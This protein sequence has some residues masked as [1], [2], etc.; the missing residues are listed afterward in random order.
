MNEID[1]VHQGYQ[2]LAR[3]FSGHVH[4]EGHY[5]MALC[6]E[7][8]PHLRDR[9]LVWTGLGVNSL[10]AKIGPQTESIR[11]K[12]LPRTKDFY[13]DLLLT[14]ISYRTYNCEDL[15]GLDVFSD[16]LPVSHVFEFKFLSAFTTLSRKIAREDTAK[17]RV[18][19]GYL[20][21][22]LGRMPYLEQVVF[23]FPRKGV[24]AKSTGLLQRWFTADGFKDQF[25]EVKV[26]IV[27]QDGAI[28]TVE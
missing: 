11:Q 2:E 28:V 15:T 18:L 10:R 13:A 8:W 1:Y 27:D 25:P 4:R 26:L 22:S 19:G 6:A 16:S 17:L 5:T 12:Y 24:R 23:N 21:K 9:M 7:L 3:K 20:E 14:N